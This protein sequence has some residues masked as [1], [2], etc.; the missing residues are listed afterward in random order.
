[1]IQE[2]LEGWY[3]SKY[4]HEGE[5]R[6]MAVTHLEPIAAR[7]VFPC[8]DEPALKAKFRISVTVPADRTVISNMDPILVGYEND[9]KTVTF[10]TTPIM[11]TYL[12][13]VVVGNFDMI[14]DV[15]SGVTIRVYTPVGGKERGRFA[16]QV[17]KSVLTFFGEYFNSPYPLDKLVCRYDSKTF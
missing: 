7:K 8:G 12:L 10:A 3:R 14:S 17:A 9:M 11:S 1:M 2:S 13:A 15:A 5:V 4:L 6:Y 16:L